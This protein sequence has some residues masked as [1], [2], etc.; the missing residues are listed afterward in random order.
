MSSWLLPFFFLFNKGNKRNSQNNINKNEKKMEAFPIKTNVESEKN[1]L[2]N[3]QFENVSV[4]DPS[5]I[6]VDDTY[7]VFGTHVTA[8]KSK[9]LM[10]WTRFTNGYTTPN[11][12]LYGDMSANLAETFKWA[13]EDDANCKGGFGVWA[14]EPFWN[15]DYL[16]KDGTKGAYM[17]YYSAS[18]TPIRSAIGF[19]VAKE[20]EGPYQYVDTL[21]YSGFTRDDAYDKRSNVN[22]KWSN[23]NILQLIK[24]GKIRNKDAKVDWFHP[25][26]AYNNSMYPNAIDANLFYDETGKLWMTYGSWS[27]GIFILELDKESGRAI[28]PGEDGV[29]EDGRIIDRY[30]GTKIAGGYRKSCEGPYVYFDTE[31]R[32]YYLFVTYGWLGANGEYQMRVF[33]SKKPDGPY[34]D[35]SGQDAVLKP[36]H[37]FMGV[38]TTDLN[39]THD[40]DHAPF[41]N[42]LFGHFQFVENVEEEVGYNYVSSGHNSVYVDVENNLR[43]LVFHTRF[44]NRG[45]RHELRIH[46]LFMNGDAWPVVAPSRYTGESL[47][48]I[49]KDQI[50]GTYQF[51][52]HEKDISKVVKKTSA[53]T[54]QEDGTI[55]GST[56][57]SW[58]LIN[59]YQAEINIA[60]QTYKGVFLQQWNEVTEQ[61][62]TAFT[63]LSNEGKSI[64][65][66][67]I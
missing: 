27:G 2:I 4:H 3:P 39:G 66:I 56:Q 5:I 52:N 28:Y 33:R 53:I 58:K 36:E 35:I 20:I 61:V 10:K 65:G 60:G 51:V 44:L 13:G 49:R 59:K 62:D 31:T 67:R 12:T 37:A 8:A 19:A 22:K 57:G 25:D 17:L 18:S 46:Q 55:A 24:A 30:F 43:L 23:T 34:V 32:F 29:T 47:Q 6:K 11:N 14:P 15:R 21:I 64:W 48:V 54:L 50:I 16:H 38:D 42:K 7:Y 26:G 40:T 45:E 1:A 63:A 41:G 9:D